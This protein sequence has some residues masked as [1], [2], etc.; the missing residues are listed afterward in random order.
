MT[1]I[2]HTWCSV[3]KQKIFCQHHKYLRGE[4]G[5]EEVPTKASLQQTEIPMKAYST[6]AL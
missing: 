5:G 4:R 6:T 3:L 2:W 1:Q